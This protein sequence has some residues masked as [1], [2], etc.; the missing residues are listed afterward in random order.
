MA[1]T[2]YLDA[3]V[4]VPLFMRDALTDRARQYLRNARPALLV[5]DLGA[6]E[7]S[8]AVARKVRM[9]ELSTDEAQAAFSTFDIWIASETGRAQ[10]SPDDAPMAERFIRRLDLTLRAPDAMHIA[11]ALRLG[12]TLATFDK[13]MEDSARALGCP[14]ADA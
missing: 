5:S 4:I 14:L 8:S 10:I 13:A 6:A 12:A 2:V 11:M 3:S 1:L 7:F 9:G